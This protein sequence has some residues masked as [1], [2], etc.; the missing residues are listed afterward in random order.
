MTFIASDSPQNTRPCTKF[1]FLFLSK[2]PLKKILLALNFSPINVE[3]PNFS[4]P[5]VIHTF[6]TECVCDVI[7]CQKNSDIVARNLTAVCRFRH[8]FLHIVHKKNR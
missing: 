7:P 5:T 3:F 1:I 2:F 4:L 8:V 6:P